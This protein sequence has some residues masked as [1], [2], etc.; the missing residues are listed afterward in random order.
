[1]N[2]S[3][4]QEGERAVVEACGSDIPL[5]LTEMGLMQGQTVE[6]IKRAP[7]GDPLVFRLDGTTVAID[8]K[9]AEGIRVRPLN[10]SRKGAVQ[11]QKSGV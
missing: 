6:M 11:R 8:R 7:L 1:M 2:L 4:L 9:T 10:G 3:E 5:K